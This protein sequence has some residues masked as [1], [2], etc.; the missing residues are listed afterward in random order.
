MYFRALNRLPLSLLAFHIGIPTNG[1]YIA[2]SGIIRRGGH[3]FAAPP[4]F[5][6]CMTSFY[7]PFVKHEERFHFPCPPTLHSPASGCWSCFGA[8]FLFRPLYSL[9]HFIHVAH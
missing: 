4:S 9:N 6:V 8:Q 3:V 1:N 7:T 5:C 2:S